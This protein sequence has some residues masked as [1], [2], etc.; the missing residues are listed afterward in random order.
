MSEQTFEHLERQIDRLI[1]RYHNLQDE[2][3]KLLKRELEWKTERAQ[4]LQTRN[5]TQSKV[6]AMIS[7]LKAMEQQ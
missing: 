3:E 2:N 1:E 5:S 4:L 6:E 7:R